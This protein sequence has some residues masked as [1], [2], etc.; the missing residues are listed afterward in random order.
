MI[1][2]VPTKGYTGDFNQLPKMIKFD[3]VNL[4][5]AI[6]FEV[7]SPGARPEKLNGTS[8]PLWSYRVSDD[9]RLIVYKWKEREWMLMICGHHDY[10]YDKA[11]KLRLQ[12]V[13]GERLPIVVVEEIKRVVVKPV[14][15]FEK[16][17]SAA[18]GFSGLSEED[19]AS[20]GVP[21]EAQAALLKI[22]T[23]ED[24]LSFLEKHE[25][26]SERLKDVLMDLFADSARLPEFAKEWEE[27]KSHPQIK[28]AL[29]DSPTAAEQIAIFDDEMMSKFYNGKL[30][31]WQVFLHPSQRR[32]VEKETNG[33][34]MVTGAAGTGKTVVAIHRIKWLLE[35]SQK[36]DALANGGKI[37]FLT[38][39]ATLAETSKTLLESICNSGL[40]RVTVTHLDAFI[41]P[42]WR[43]VSGGEGIA[44]YHN[45]ERDY[46][47]EYVRN[48]IES[49][50]SGKRDPAFIYSEFLEV[51][52]EYRISSEAEYVDFVRPAYRPRINRE[53]RPQLWPVFERIDRLMPGLAKSPKVYVL[54][55]LSE[56]Y[57][58]S[59][60]GLPDEYGSV[61]VD[62][63]QDFG[64]SEY[65][66]L[67]AMTKNTIEHPVP[68][69]LFLAG[70]GHQRIYGR[71]GSFRSCGIDIVN[72]S[73]HLTKCYR[74]TQKIREYAEHL[75]A[76]VKV[77]NLN[78]DP[79]SLGDGESIEV[80]VSPEEFFQP[81]GHDFDLMNRHI[82]ETIKR[83]M[84][85]GSNL[86]SDYAILLRNAKK[87]YKETF[88]L[89][90]A[91]EAL[92]ALEIPCEVVSKEMRTGENSVKI[93][94]M[95]RAKG[96]QFQGVVIIL[97]GWPH[98]PLEEGPDGKMCISTDEGLVKATKDEEKCLLYM[99]IMRAVSR[100]LLTRTGRCPDEL[101]WQRSLI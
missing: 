31:N 66:F 36:I 85:T 52:L 67:A 9:I 97:N 80:G 64:A 93:M 53:E 56:L 6:Q 99:A 59:L 101:K 88:F 20:V 96:L 41:Q 73:E 45:R 4:V 49:C 13:Q 100:V 81:S 38:Y 76:D 75:I 37:L 50:Y 72:R 27:Q 57:A 58:S 29:K 25:K 48:A 2:T 7:V 46:P 28:S 74:T 87:G 43:L 15:E 78:G 63:V 77:K 95:H 19:M 92:T 94:T 84:E 23:E 47:P 69:S 22:T 34:A 26:W 14:V 65:R 39:T 40:D 62:E 55:R 11:K 89:D 82:A 32:A 71:S 33:P 17:K 1:Q 3:V 79:D 60:P 54:N 98:K 91:K 8:I 5:S 70:D 83:W 42:I 35:H 10:A 16:P 18:S 21:P 44:Y 86:Y 24:L 68:Y 61:L 12:Q 51:V 90:K 30:E